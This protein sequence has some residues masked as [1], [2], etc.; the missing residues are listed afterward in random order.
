MTQLLS[1]ISDD[2][3]EPLRTASAV[4][5]PEGMSQRSTGSTPS[6]M[7]VLADTA[8]LSISLPGN[9]SRLDAELLHPFD[10]HF[11]IS[12]VVPAELLLCRVHHLAAAVVPHHPPPPPHPR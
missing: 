10:D 2:A 8:R 12:F 3:L 11:E 5:S 6:K 7:C 4:F 9:L 1:G